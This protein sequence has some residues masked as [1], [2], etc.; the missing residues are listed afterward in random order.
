[1]LSL[2]T[3]R[4]K[5]PK[6]KLMK[7]ISQSAILCCFANAIELYQKQNENCLGCSSRDHVVKDCPKDL[8]KTVRK[9]SLNVKEGTM[10]KAG[11][12]P[13]KPVVTELESPD[14][15]PRM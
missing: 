8:S 5:E 14:E 13:Q 7:Q 9:A 4:T 11:Q 15:A 3:E 12:T 10:K 2:Q 6:M 1:M